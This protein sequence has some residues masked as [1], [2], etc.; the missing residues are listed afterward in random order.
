MKGAS[1]QVLSACLLAVQ[2]Q[3]E[4]SIESCGGVVYW[5]SPSKPPLQDPLFTYPIDYLR[6]APDAP[7]AHKSDHQGI[8]QQTPAMETGGNFPNGGS[9]VVH[10]SI[11]DAARTRHMWQQM[12]AQQQNGDY[13]SHNTRSV[14][15]AS[16][17]PING[18]GHHKMTN[19][20]QQIISGNGYLH[21]QPPVHWRNPTIP[22]G[23][24][25]QQYYRNGQMPRSN[26]WQHPQ[27]QTTVSPAA[28]GGRVTPDSALENEKRI[29]MA[30]VLSH[31]DVVTG[32]G[33]N[34]PWQLRQRYQ[35]YMPPGNVKVELAVVGG[36]LDDYNFYNKQHVNGRSA[37]V[38]PTGQSPIEKENFHQYG[39]QI[40]G[41]AR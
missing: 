24:S 26:H 21:E 28:N 29:F 37:S 40:N 34:I 35:Q 12:A 11:A 17:G 1:F 23:G 32:L 8:H 39:G 2:D 33:I 36:G 7:T 16:I 4:P 22:N 6:K 9:A 41:T 20:Q 31:P 18:D 3:S 25:D 30:Y 5:Q 38:G 27:Q 10:E 14:T 19:G 15:P 13:K